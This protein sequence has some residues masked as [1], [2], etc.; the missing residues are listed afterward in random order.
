MRIKFEKRDDGKWWPTEANK[1]LLWQQGVFVLNVSDT[2]V[3][4]GSIWEPLG[5]QKRDE[6]VDEWLDENIEWVN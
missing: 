3:F 5:S 2:D 6:I 4:L 1:F